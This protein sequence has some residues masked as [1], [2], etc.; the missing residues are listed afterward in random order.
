MSRV[1]LLLDE[2]RW[3]LIM[4]AIVLGAVSICHLIP[5]EVEP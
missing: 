1:R 5:C 2:L 3:L 4:L